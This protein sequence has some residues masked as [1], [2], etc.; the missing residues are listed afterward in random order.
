MSEGMGTNAAGN[1]QLGAPELEAA[2]P[3]D[4]AAEPDDQADD[5]GQADD[6]QKPPAKR[7]K[8]SS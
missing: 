3:D 4:Q 8:A 6:W 7:S 2:E 5:D 1:T